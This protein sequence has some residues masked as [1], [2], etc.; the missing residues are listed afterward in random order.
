MNRE[1]LGKE[2]AESALK[3]TLFTLRKMADGGMYD[4]VGGGFH[5]Y[6]VDER[7]HVPHF[8]KMLYD[9]GQLVCT[10]LDAYQITHDPFLADTALGVLDYIRRDMT[11]EQGQFYSAE[12][13]DS[14]VPENPQE[15]A[16]GAFYVWEQGQLAEI[17]GDEMAAMFGFYYGVEEGGNVRSDPH[18]EFPNK[19]V[20]IVSHTVEETG[21]RFGKTPEEIRAT[22][23]AARDRLFEVR[24]KR[25]RPHLDDKTITAWN[26]LMISAFARAYQV[27]GRREDL[28]SAQRAAAFIRERLYNEQTGVILR[29]YRAGDA[30]IDG[31]VDDYAFFIQGLLDLYEASFE[32]D[33]LVWALKLQKKQNELFWDEKEG[34]YF[35]TSGTDES[36]L[37]R[38]K[39]DYDGAEPSPNSVAVLNLARLSQLFDTA[40]LRVK[41]EQTLKAFGRRLER[42]PHAMPQMMVALDYYLDE[43]KQIILAGNPDAPDTLAMLRTVHERFIPNKILMLVDGGE[44]QQRL[45]R[46]IEFLGS[47][48]MQDGKATAYVCEG[49]VCQRPATDLASLV[50]ILDKRNGPAIDGGK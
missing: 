5:R 48:E 17:L 32:V 46:H 21:K 40:A 38:M 20:L 31:Y 43:P 7:W 37:L 33:H 15:H 4:H 23:A 18:G 42:A 26:G 14:A 1:T 19:N 39:N 49:F 16:E 27:L 50:K 9:Q 28:M 22:L 13:A 41:A 45:A 3:M 10:Y 8:E 30:A 44:S 24:E 6:S 25:P 12:D 47:L 34:G 11:G 36:I 29:R 2:A 35:N